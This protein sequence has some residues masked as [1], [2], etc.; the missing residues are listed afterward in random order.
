MTIAANDKWPFSK[1]DMARCI[2]E[3]DWS[4]TLLG[5]IDQWP[6]L[7]RSTVE[8]LLSH[9]FP[10]I[11]L[12]GPDLLQIYNDGYADLMVDKHPW[13]LGIANPICWPEVWHINEPIYARV[14]AGE[15]VTIENGLYP[16]VRRGVRQDIWLSL[17]Y[18]PVLD[19]DGT[20]A[21]VLVTI[22]ETTRR[23]LAEAA[24]EERSQQLNMVV[25][26]LQHR[27]RNIL[28]VV[29]SIFSRTVETG[30]DFEEIAGH[31]R[32]RLD[33]LARVQVIV[34]Q[35]A[36]GTADF[37]NLLRDELVSVGVQEGPNLEIIG[38]D[39][40]MP[41]EIF[42]TMGLAVHELTTNAVKYGAFRTETGK[43][44]VTW[45]IE[46][47]GD[48]TPMLSFLWK[49]EGVPAVGL[50]PRHEGFGRELIEEA[51]PYRL[52]GSACL[53]FLPGGIQCSIKVPLP[54]KSCGQQT[55]FEHRS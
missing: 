34:T 4:D 53:E 17:T 30:T 15:T 19:T 13:G 36:D 50:A 5:P 39:V 54:G 1:A 20:V 16:L 29:R 24:L 25:A 46:S 7:L 37:E 55:A 47:G 18:S 40:Q 12:W 11:I 45:Q 22:V 2:R 27:V 6:A 9:G 23:V 35:S 28:T 8:M 32:G 33:A 10:M 49:E 31:F 48:A 43:L 38:Q 41:A 21:G 3:R 26:E 51:I 52:G 14:F 42:E 44:T